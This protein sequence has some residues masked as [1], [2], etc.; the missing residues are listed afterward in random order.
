MSRRP[1][2]SFLFVASLLPATPSHAKVIHVG[3]G[4]ANATIQAGVD[5]ANDGDKVLVEPGVYIENVVINGYS[6]LTVE[7]RGKVIVDARP[8]APTG[9]GPGFNLFQSTSI[10][11]K[12]FTIRHARASGSP[13]GF[14]VLV[15]GGSDHRLE[16]ITTIG[17][18]G[19][20]NVTAARVTVTGGS[21]IFNGSGAVE[22][23][24][25]DALVSKVDVRGDGQ[26]G[27]KVTGSRANV[28][29]CK[30][31]NIE[32]GVGIEVDGADLEISRNELI[33]V[34]DGEAILVDGPS[35]SIRK[36]RIER[37]GDDA[38][39]ISVANATEGS[40]RDNTMRDCPEGGISLAASTSDL[41]LIGNLVESSGFEGEPGF[42]ILGASHV[43]RN[44]VA[45]RNGGDGFNLMGNSMMVT[46]NTSTG[47]AFDGFDIGVGSNGSSLSDNV[48]T[49]NS[50]EGFDNSGTNTNFVDNVSKKNRQPFGNSGT[51][52]TNTG[53]TPPFDPNVPPEID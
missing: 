9:T 47:N 41:E 21:A 43:V 7:G 30:V 19:G 33:D 17:C 3:S 20:I 27:I 48:A 25:D 36:N 10:K 28:T 26:F 50:A 38:V 13:D 18:D 2:V 1:L 49:Q 22:I 37:A 6:N 35:V 45:R 5:A 29:R 12:N 11:L 14:G 15:S 23:T 40:I 31:R 44:N 46:H 52:G 39:G 51:V 32:D 16:K 34:A 8:N 53:N 42:S 24:G 4:F